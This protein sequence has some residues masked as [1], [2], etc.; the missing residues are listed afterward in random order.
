MGGQ[1]KLFFRHIGP[2]GSG[3]FVRVFGWVKLPPRHIG[4]VS[5]G[6]SPTP[7]SPNHQS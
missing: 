2:I 5:S 7:V 1:A 3:T 6:T 4:P